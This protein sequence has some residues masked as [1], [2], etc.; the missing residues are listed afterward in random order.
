LDSYI[1]I[2]IKLVV[3]KSE[4]S[5]V[6]ALKHCKLIKSKYEYIKSGKRQTK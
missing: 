5:F 1:E 4:N 6:N 2:K 3:N